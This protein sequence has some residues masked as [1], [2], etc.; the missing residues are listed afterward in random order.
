M[1]AG[2]ATEYSELVL[3]THNIE[4]SGVQELG[5]PGVFFESL[6]V[7]LQFDRGRIVVV[8]IAVGHRH[9]GGV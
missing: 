4:L 5:G 7:Y 1:T 8:T 2:F 6:V 9:D 3:Q